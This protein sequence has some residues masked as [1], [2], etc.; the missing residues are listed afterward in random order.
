MT[1]KTTPIL[2]SDQAFGF[3]SVTTL[4]FI[5]AAYY[6]VLNIIS[7]F[8]NV[9]GPWRIPVATGVVTLLFFGSCDVFNAIRTRKREEPRVYVENYYLFREHYP[10]PN[11]RAQAVAAFTFIEFFLAV[12]L[13]VIAIIDA[14]RDSFHNNT[15][16]RCTKS[17]CS[18]LHYLTGLVK[19][20][21]A[22]RVPSAEIAQDCEDERL[23]KV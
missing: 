20:P 17:C 7:K 8:H 6:A 14:K 5:S 22:R 19:L 10:K 15:L 12:I 4:A 18:C 2:K 11:A 1:D 16:S 9:F 3:I 21:L 13:L 23:R